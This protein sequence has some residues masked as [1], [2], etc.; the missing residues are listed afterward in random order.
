MFGDVAHGNHWISGRSGP[1]DVLRD[2]GLGDTKGTWGG[3]GVGSGS[4]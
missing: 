2:I 1:E 4:R 3:G